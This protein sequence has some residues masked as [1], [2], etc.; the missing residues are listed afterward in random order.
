MNIVLL[1]NMYSALVLGRFLSGTGQRMASYENIR[2]WKGEIKD[3]I[4]LNMLV[5][6]TITRR[7]LDGFHLVSYIFYWLVTNREVVFSVDG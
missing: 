5:T 2:L 7:D 3:Y 4:Q 1:G 6:S